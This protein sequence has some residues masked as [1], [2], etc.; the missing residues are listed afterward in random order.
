[1][2]RKTRSIVWASALLLALALL[3]S[4]VSNVS[5]A[6]HE[7]ALHNISITTEDDVLI[8]TQDTSKYDEVWTKAGVQ[9]PSD[10][11]KTFNQMG[12]IASFYEPSSS[13]TVNLISNRAESTI[14]VFTF[15]DMTDDEV[16]NYMKAQMKENTDNGITTS[17]SVSREFGEYPFIK[18][19]IDAKGTANPCSEVI[20][21]TIVN[22]EMLQFDAFNQGAGDVDE[23]FLKK[24]I[25]GLSITRILTREE[26]EVEMRKARTRL[27]VMLAAFIVLIVL[28]ITLVKWLGKR[29]DAKAQRISDAVT[30]F[31]QKIAD[32]E[33][34]TSEGPL[35]TV[36]THYNSELFD[37]LGMY[38]AW[39]K[40][41]F[42][43]IMSL[44]VFLLLAVFM[45]SEGSYLYAAIMLGFMIALL[46]MHY[47][48]AEKTKE[49][50]V[51]RYD[52]KSNPAPVFYFYRNYMRISGITGSGEYIYDQIT[53]L[54]EWQGVVYMFLG[55]T[56]VYPIRKEDMTGCTLSDIKKLAGK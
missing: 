20:Y 24:I 16:L 18:I 7:Y 28:I 47:S 37:R 11:L 48:A 46:Y 36:T 9:N 32:G 52:V 51:K 1:M 56:Q 50:L 2:Y 22:G 41:S 31:R 43:F 17:L 40:P 55:G 21:G 19:V 34:D 12:V 8:M 44:V 30:V 35:Y 54:R 23:S 38:L 5:A 39:L 45:A 15:K 14:D 3:I 42:G 4:P 49:A 25:G 6:V 10:T 26:Y 13:L 53:E 27:F 29:R 33:I